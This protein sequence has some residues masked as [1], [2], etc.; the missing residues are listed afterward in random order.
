MNAIKQ[1]FVLF[2]VNLISLPMRWRSSMIA[3]IGVAGVVAILVGIFSLLSGFEKT[4]ELAGDDDTAIVFR[5]GSGSEMRSYMRADHA[6]IITDIAGERLATKELFTSADIELPDSDFFV[7]MAMRGISKESLDLRGGVNIIDGRLFTWGTTEIIIG[8][9]TLKEQPHLAVNST[10]EIGGVDWTITGI[11]EDGGS[12]SESEFW[13]DA[14]A[15]RSLFNRGYSSVRIK[16]ANAADIDA[17]RDAIEKDSRLRMV[18]MSEKE[19]YASQS[20]DI[21]TFIKFIG[22][23]LVILMAMGTIFVSLNSMSAAVASR[24]A[25]IS[26]LQAIGFRP[27]RVCMSVLMESVFLALFGGVIG[28][29][30]VYVLADGHQVSTVNQLSF[31]QVN[32]MFNVTPELLL[33]GIALAMSIGLIGGLSAIFRVLRTPIVMSLK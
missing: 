32:F 29:L 25:E 27:V 20:D 30:A 11:F 19:Y 22:Y 4:M 31:S 10:V 6:K 5:S 8:R 33:Q 15:L 28:A 17:I 18:V 9:S 23:P 2:F 3:V 14:L 24:K 16:V 13:F 21:E 7:N 26:T 12:V 1:T